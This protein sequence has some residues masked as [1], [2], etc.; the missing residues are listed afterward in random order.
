MKNNISIVFLWAKVGGY[1]EAVLKSLSSQTV[2]KINVVHWDKRDLNST[3]HVIDDVDNINFYAR[4][5]TNDESILKLLEKTK[6]DIIVVSGWMDSGYIRTCKKYK[7]INPMVKI[8]AGIDDIWTGSFRQR[9][10]QIYYRLFYRELFN[11]M[12]ISGQPQFSF[13]QRFGYDI[14]SIISNLYSADTE[15]FKMRAG[16]TKRFIFVGRFV[17]VKALDLLVESY[18]KLP[19]NVQSEWPLILIG[20]GDQK[21]KILEQKNPNI[22]VLPFLQPEELRRE[23]LKG[24]VGCLPSHKD[25]WGVV[26]HEYALMGLPILASSGCGATTEF[27]ISG[28]N[29]FLFRKGDVND[30]HRAMKEFTSLTE[31]D[32]SQLAVNGT[33]FGNRITSELSAASLLSVYQSALPH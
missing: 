33:K 32:L 24:G 30:L 4:S 8:V 17:K 5:E 3:Q 15:M 1:L 12:W 11:V 22:K 19:A 13:A 21:P 20:D 9:L 26:L 16:I 29:G 14:G 25:Q 23:L 10:G 18:C 7:K 31:E 27:L 28:F 2:G 6:P